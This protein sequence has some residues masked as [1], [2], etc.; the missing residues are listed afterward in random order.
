MSGLREFEVITFDADQTLIDFRPAM[1]Q[2]LAESLGYLKQTIPGAADL[3]VDDLAQIR[4][5]EAERLGPSATMETIRL[6]AF[7]ATLSKL[8]A[9]D[10]GAE[11]FTK[12]YL[13]LRFRLARRYDDAVP[14]LRALAPDYRL[15]LA[16]NGNSY[17][18]RSGLEGHFAFVVLAQ[19][20][21]A[22]KPD[23]AFYK[24]VIEAAECDPDRILHVGDSLDEDV[25]AAQ[26][27]GIRAIWLNRDAE[28]RGAVE[29]WAEV[30]T[31][32]Q[33]PGLLP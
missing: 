2:A 24:N 6:A 7:R 15:G 16:T 17:P 21:G 22:R 10:S 31:L 12:H 14:T 27:V 11:K 3:T 29:P 20:V 30:S 9:D 18:D 32:S 33:I 5:G 28:L 23:P 25:A 1:R 8:G 26:A 19:D 13:D 4:D